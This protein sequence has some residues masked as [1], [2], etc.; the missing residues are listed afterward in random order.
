MRWV[1]IDVGGTFTDIVVY[2]QV[3]GQLRS[4]KRPSTPRKPEVGVFDALGALDVTLADVSRFRHGATVATNTA[5]QRNGA[6]VG[7][8]T[9]GGFRDVLIVG[10]GNRLD[11]YNIKAT[12]PQGLVERRHILEVSERLRADGSVMQP[13]DEQTVRD[14][15]AKFGELGVATVA[16]C[17]LHAYANPA[18]EHRAAEILRDRMP[19]IP[20]FTSA[21]V[22]PEHREYERFAT[23]ALNAYVGPGMAGYLHR[24]KQ[25]LDEGNLS[26]SPEIMSSSGGSWSFERMASLPVNSML[27][28]PAG[29]VIGAV[30]V[31]RKMAA[32]DL[33]TYDMGGTSTDVA[34]VRDG[35]YAL[36]ME[37]SIAELPNRVA[38]IEINTVGAGGGS[39]AYLDEGGFLNVGPRSAGADP[40]PACYG[41]GGTEPTVTDA[42]VVL[43][44]FRPDSPIGGRINI[45]VAAAERA[46]DGLAE[47]LGL[48]RMQTA[49]GIVQIANTRMTTA[50]KEISVMRGIDPRGFS[51][52]AYGG[53]GP[54]H[55]AEIAYELGMRQVVVPPLPGAFS[56]FGLLVADRRLDFSHAGLL[57]LDG[58]DYSQLHARFAPLKKEARMAL[59]A[60]G[61]ASDDMRIECSADL[62]FEGQAFELATPVEEGIQTTEELIET[63]RAIYAERYSHADKGRVEC[64]CL[65]VSAFGLAEKPHSSREDTT[66]SEAA[67]V[68]EVF[69]N[70]TSV[71]AEVVQRDTL[72][73]VRGPAF[74]EEPGASTWVPGGFCAR[75]DDSGA[76]VLTREASA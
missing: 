25:R 76:L 41:R 4:E 21:E 73:E 20:V 75:L 32:K 30:E 63:F 39:I 68:R 38:Q 10:R 64:V 49:E 72:S 53:A 2:D 3:T 43:G 50:I 69:V 52:F 65:R 55:A 7:V 8:L 26:V 28:G 37:G 48:P 1:G 22:L 62:R 70:G 67:G 15:A 71:H 58:L 12:R 56:A 74:V 29:G 54:L 59:A 47:K 34:M 18:H 9:T 14:S 46:V 13:L 23:T 51:L 16:V 17:F 36:S 61:F 42:N 35:R 60:E 27:S 33:I 57:P 19:D 5:L 24:L 31:C 40:G 44:R 66:A 11:L 6:M 45:D